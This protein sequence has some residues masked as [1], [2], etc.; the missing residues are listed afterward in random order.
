MLEWKQAEKGLMWGMFFLFAGGL[1]LGKLVTETGAAAKLAEFIAM[2]PLSGGGLGTVGIF[3]VFAT[4]LSEISSNTAAASISIPVVE[5]IARALG[6]SHIPY[7]LIT[8]VAVNC[9]Y[10]LPVSIRAIPVGYGLEPAELFHKGAVLSI[11]NMLLTTVIGWL[12]IT[13]IPWFGAS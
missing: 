10:I 1:A 13:Y 11:L 5:S 9:A 6:L 3:T 4:V 12:V 8:I 2:L 7:V